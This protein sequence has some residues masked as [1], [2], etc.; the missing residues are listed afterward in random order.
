M[1]QLAW[2]TDSEAVIKL[3][4]V[5]ILEADLAGA[6]SSIDHRNQAVVKVL[7]AGE[8]IGVLGAGEVLIGAA[9]SIGAARSGLEPAIIFAPGTAGSQSQRDELI[10][11]ERASH[12]GSISESLSAQ[13]IAN[14]GIKTLQESSSRVL[15]NC[16]MCQRI[17]SIQ[18][19][20]GDRCSPVSAGLEAAI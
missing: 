14:R 10:A 3:T 7:S 1:S 5:S 19:L 13:C 4:G 9:D 2:N 20:L 12:V 16:E 8:K 17:C 6:E 11:I 15:E 18:L